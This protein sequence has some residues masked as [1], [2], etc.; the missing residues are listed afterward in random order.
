MI[1]AEN[2]TKRYGAALAVDNISFS[3]EPGEICGFLGPN[4]AGKTTTMRIITGFMPPTE[5]RVMVD[6]LDVAENPLEVKKRVGYLPESTPLY[7]EMRVGEY[8]DFAAEIKGLKGAE[9]RRQV[10]EVMESVRIADRR[11][12]LIKSLSKGYKQRVGLA[13]ALL[14]DPKILVL[15][16]P[17]IGLDP[18]QIAEI[19]SLIK[20]LAGKRTVILSTH[21]L[22]EAQMICSK[23][24]II[25]KGKVIAAD[26]PQNLS[27]RFRGGGQTALKIAGPHEQVINAIKAMPEVE[28]VSATVEGDVVSCAITPK[29]GMNLRKAAV[30]LV[31]QMDWELMEL[32]AGGAMS[33]EDVYLKL[34]TEEPQAAG[35]EERAGQ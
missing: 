28:N 14:A 19:R 23:V 18:K 8:L 32:S 1:K 29:G 20:E 26:T 12:S 21:I 35:V 11:R 10:D 7:T 22:P 27:S 17:T 31:A 4:G 25:N 9:K 5:G 13:Q 6:G 30:K 3:M 33:L 2:L 16:E 34:V 15:D 24:M